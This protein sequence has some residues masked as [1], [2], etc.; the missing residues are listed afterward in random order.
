VWRERQF[1][2]LRSIS[3]QGEQSAT[4][5]STQHT[6]LAQHHRCGRCAQQEAGGK[7][8]NDQDGNG[9]TAG[10][11][12]AGAEQREATEDAEMALDGGN[13]LWYGLFHAT[14]S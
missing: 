13:A 6:G 9:D 12:E 2:V 10:S 5:A 7:R 8:H 14:T 1:L 11:P 3:S 4:H